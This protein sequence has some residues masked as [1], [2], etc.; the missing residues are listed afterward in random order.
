MLRVVKTPEKPRPTRALTMGG[1][2]P[3]RIP[4]AAPGLTYAQGFSGAAGAPPRP[5]LRVVSAR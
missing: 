1:P 5:H 2:P 4:G 3:E